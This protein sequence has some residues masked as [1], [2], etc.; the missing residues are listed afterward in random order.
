MVCKMVRG[1]RL[2]SA[3]ATM[4]RKKPADLNAFLCRLVLF[5]RLFPRRI[6][7]DDVQNK[8]ACGLPGAADNTG[9][10]FCDRAHER[11]TVASG[12]AGRTT[13]CISVSESLG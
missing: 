11:F 7:G 13:R 2:I 3:V 5:T 8:K 4:P 12:A 10:C 1:S 6:D 9:L